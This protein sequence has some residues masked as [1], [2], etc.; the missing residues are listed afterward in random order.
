M[1]A[2]WP[3][4][5]WRIGG[6]SSRASFT[7]ASRFTRSE[8]V[9]SSC[10]KLSRRPPPVGQRSPPARRP[11]ARRPRV[12]L[13][14][15]RVRDRTRVSGALRPAAIRRAPVAH[16]PCERS[17]RAWRRD[18]RAPRR[19]PARGRRSLRSEAP[20]C[21]RAP[22]DGSYQGWAAPAPDSCP[23][24][25][26]RRTEM[27]RP[28]RTAAAAPTPR[29][30]CHNAYP[31]LAPRRLRP[32]GDQGSR[33]RRRPEP[34]CHWVTDGRREV[35]QLSGQRAVP[36][37]V[38]DDGEVVADSK[39]IVEWAE[40]NPAHR[41]DGIRL[42]FERR[43]FRHVGRGPER[44][45]PPR[46]W[47]TLLRYSDAKSRMPLPRGMRPAC[48]RGRSRY[49]RRCQICSPP[50]AYVPGPLRPVQSARFAGIS[51]FV[52]EIVSVM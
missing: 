46:A 28:S 29:T 22:R 31:P 14:R 36:V 3:A 11:H 24:K 47:P 13:R 44:Q 19:S 42:R 4:P 5:R 8:A 10:E 35:E 34:H 33:P 12:A 30:R 6:T 43:H 50:P 45:R 26:P 37:L 25:L 2:R 23:R 18:R 40:A 7:G 15:L 21:H 49:E 48:P 20:S 52:G 39:R 51:P 32:R 17:G 9:S 27:R 38:T 41:P 16:R 1:N